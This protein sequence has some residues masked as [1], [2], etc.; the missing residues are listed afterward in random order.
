MTIGQ[1]IYYIC[2]ALTIVIILRAFVSWYAINTRSSLV[3]LLYRI[4]EPML[5]PLRRIIPRTG[6][7]DFTPA[8]AVVLLLIIGNLARWLL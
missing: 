2:L 5:A 6:A 4:T 3:P 8:V 7:Y 1:I